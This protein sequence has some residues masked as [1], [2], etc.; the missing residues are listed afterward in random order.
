[1]NLNR[2]KNNRLKDLFGRRITY[3]R[4]TMIPVEELQFREEKVLI[5]QKSKSGEHIRPLGDDIRQGELLYTMGTVLKPV[6]IG[7]LASIGRTRVKVIPRPKI[8]IIATGSEIA[9]PGKTLIPGQIYNSNEASLHSLLIKDGH[10]A[11]TVIPPVKDDMEQLSRI[12]R[13][14][15]ASYHLIITF[16]G[17]SMGDFDFIPQAVNNLGGTI[18]FHKVKVKPGKPVLMA[19]YNLSIEQNYNGNRERWLVGLP[20]N[21]VSSVAGYHFYVKRVLGRL[22]GIP[23]IPRKTKARLTSNVQ[24]SGSRQ[25]VIGVRVEETEQGSLAYPTRRQKSGR[26]SSIKGIDGFIIADADKKL[27]ESGSDVQVEWF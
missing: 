5:T 23:F 26:L 8:A 21:P 3:L 24:L 10:T 6:D 17:V 7:V 27:L 19:R 16:G 20:G 11:V 1:M 9:A 15:F 22:M 25:K 12:I 2:P 4:A 18:V 13:D 14:S